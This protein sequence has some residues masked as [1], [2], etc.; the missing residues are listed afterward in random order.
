MLGEFKTE[1]ERLD[2]AEA[3]RVEEAAAE[4][5]RN[6]EHLVDSIARGMGYSRAK[7]ER[8]AA[9]M[10]GGRARDPLAGRVR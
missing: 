3:A 4:R 8:I 7:A 5:G 2:A 9:R 1:R 6:H 10:L